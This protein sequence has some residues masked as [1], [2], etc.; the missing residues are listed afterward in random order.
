M[1]ASGI[2]LVGIALLLFALFPCFL[3]LFFKWVVLDKKSAGVVDEL[4]H[5]KAFEIPSLRDQMGDE[6]QVRTKIAERYGYARFAWP[7]SL[8]A[9]SHLIAAA[10]VW[11]ILATAFGFFPPES[12]TPLFTTAFLEAAK[13]PMVAYLG[14]TLFSY[15]HM[16]RRLYVWDLT[17]QVFWA[18]LHRTWLVLAVACVSVSPLTP[19]T[20]GYQSTTYVAFF[21][22]GFIINEVLAWMIERARKHFQIKRLQV[23]ELPLSLVHGINFWHEFRLEEEGIENVQNLATCDV[24]ELTISTRYNLRTLIDWVDQAILVHRMGEKATTLR[25]KGFIGGAIDLAWASPANN[26]DDTQ[27]ADQIAKTLET[28]PIYVR[29]LMN[30]LLEEKQI[31]VLWTLWQSDLDARERRPP[32]I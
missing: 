23:Q 27:M 11:N 3:Y 4:R 12:K 20:S 13:L 17:T 19:A 32:T 24:V 30:S 18:A 10:V 31:Q 28:E 2:Y 22:I 5:S 15:G 21:A 16:L 14:A 1:Q 9:I 6:S 8:L 29:S 26:K 7:I 25:E